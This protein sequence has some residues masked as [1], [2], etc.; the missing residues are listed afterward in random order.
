MPTPPACE[1]RGICCAAGSRYQ[2]ILAPRASERDRIGPPFRVGM[3]A[4][5]PRD[6][7][8][9]SCDNCTS[10]SNAAQADT[11]AEGIGDECD[12]S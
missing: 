10:T 12:A 9:N 1:R 11:D 6:G 3:G 8:G 2:G 7:A 4:L 5:Y